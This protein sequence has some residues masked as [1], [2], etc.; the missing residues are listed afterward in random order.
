MS[1]VNQ[2]MSEYP[3]PTQ[4]LL[5]AIIVKA[6]DT[7]HS[8]VKRRKYVGSARKQAII[9]RTVRSPYQSVQDAQDLTPSIA[10]TV[11]L[12]MEGSFFQ[13]VQI[14]AQKKRGVMH[15]IMNDE[16]LRDVGALLI[17]KPHFIYTAYSMMTLLYE[18]VLAFADT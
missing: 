8:A 7:R 18:T 9:G 5:V 12:H 4:A 11:K 16:S 6:W 10:D 13:I 14:N 1:V 3:N 17:S 2:H 15:S